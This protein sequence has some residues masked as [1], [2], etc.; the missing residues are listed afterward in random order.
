MNALIGYTGFV[1]S[2]LEEQFNFDEK[3]NSK[4]I[5]NIKGKEFDI[6]VC[7]GVRAEK[8]LANKYP[9]QDLD[10]IRDLIEILKT[11]K[12]KKFIL[13]S[14]I[15]VYR[16]PYD[17]DENTVITEDGL[18]AYGLN[19]R[20]LEKWVVNNYEDYLI[21]RLPALFGKGLKKNFIYDMQTRIPTLIMEN[22]MLE[23]LDQATKN[24]TL[25]ENYEKDINNNYVLKSK[26][27]NEERK[28]LVNEL[29][30]IGFTSLVFTDSRSTFP[31][32]DLNSLWNHIQIGIKNNLKVLNLAV[33]S[34]SAKEIAG[35]CFKKEFNNYISNREP[36]NYDM[37]TIHYKLFGGCNGYIY[38]K[39]E[40]IKQIEE[41]IN[42][43]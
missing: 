7:A 27:S 38:N 12:V 5:N 29:E 14:T 30:K 10:A 8:Y 16:E 33:E 11:V 23:L 28:K 19:R 24:E 9:D 26:I 1:G 6:I 3:Y 35:N 39:H 13:V 20:Y 34:L 36:V 4:N 37:K 42:H 31:F 18:H 21:V 22:K 25:L 32:Y 43:Y 40:V 17:V 15:D 41:F 2:N